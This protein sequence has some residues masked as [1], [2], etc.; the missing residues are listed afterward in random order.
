MLL[1][2]GRLSDA[3]AYAAAARANFQSFGDRAVQD[4]QNV[5]LLIAEIDQAMAKKSKG[6]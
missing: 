5:E 4:I 3:R 6:Q 2:A 1:R